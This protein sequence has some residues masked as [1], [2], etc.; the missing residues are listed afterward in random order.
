MILT[1][2]LNAELL[3]MK[4]TIALKMVVLSP[5]VVVLLIL[6]LGSQAPFSTFNYNGVANKWRVLASLTLR[7][8]AILMM[9]QYVTLETALIA[10]LDHSKISGRSCLPGQFRAGRCIWP[11]CLL[12]WL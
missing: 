10:G 3:K 5:A 2:V 7:V 12:Q 9:P 8:W 6:F 11:N 1:R 4:R